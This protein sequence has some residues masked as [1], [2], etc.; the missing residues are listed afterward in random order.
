MIR[1]LDLS[2]PVEVKLLR[3]ESVFIKKRYSGYLRVENDSLWLDS[4][5]VPVDN[6]EYIEGKFFNSRK[7]R[8]AGLITL[9]LGSIVALSPL[10]ATLVLNNQVGPINPL[11]IPLIIVIAPI[12]FP[13]LSIAFLAL[14]IPGSYLMKMGI[15]SIL[16]R[17]KLR[18]IRWDVDIHDSVTPTK[19]LAQNDELRGREMP[20]LFFK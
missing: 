14:T 4:M 1:E 8:S 5:Y 16:G 13:E 2:K 3:T 17:M 6:I 9:T 15:S 19:I 18:T 12:V 11:L 20:Y 7:E 10:I